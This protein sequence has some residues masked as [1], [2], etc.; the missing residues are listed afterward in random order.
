[1]ELMVVRDRIAGILIGLAAGDA[2]GGPI[3]MAVRLAESLIDRKELVPAD[4]L[5][6]YVAWHREGAFDTGPVAGNVLARIAGG[7]APEQAVRDTH[8]A[9]G[10]LTAGCNPAH[11]CGPLA[12]A[13]FINDDALPA[14]A[15]RE[16]ALTHFDPIAGDVAAAVVVLCRNLARKVNWSAS[17]KRAAIG[18]LSETQ[19]ALVPAKSD[20]IK[21]NGYAPDALA[22]AV[23]FLNEC[24]KFGP[25]LTNAATFAGSA[26]YCPVLVGAIG[27][28]RW[29]ASSLP[30][31]FF[32][33]GELFTRVSA[34]AQRLAS[35][36][37][38][39]R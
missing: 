31:K 38:T 15:V 19:R 7:E 9:R 21:P 26:N 30:A 34:A 29:G 39:S 2:R 1:M 17:L 10:G 25:A 11:R 20:R 13:Q 12:M 23:H 8:S 5:D 18:R 32:P 27:G 28:A 36:W 35:E 14:L 33:R 4:V 22:A 6:R 3:R 37:N 24:D 16:A